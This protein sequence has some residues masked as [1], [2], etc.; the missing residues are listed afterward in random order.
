MKVITLF[1]G[2]GMTD[3]GVDRVLFTRGLP[4]ADIIRYGEFSP[5]PAKAFSIMHDIDSKHNLGDLT[6]IDARKL[7]QELKRE[8]NDDIDF[9]V[10]SFPCQSFSNAGKGLGFDDKDKGNLFN[11][12]ADIIQTLKPA[13]VVF[14]N[15]KGLLAPKY[16]A[17]AKI[18]QT[19]SGYICS[20]KVLNAI[21]YNVPQNRAR[22]FIVCIRADVAKKH[23]PFEFPATVPLT[24]TVADYIDGDVCNADRKCPQDMKKFFDEE[25]HR[26]YSSSLG[27]KKI[28]DTIKQG[29]HTSGWTRRSIFSIHGVS[30]TLITANEALYQEL[31]G[32]LTALERW[33]LMSLDD[34]DYHDLIDAGISKRQIDHIAGNGIV[35]VVFEHLFES[36]IDQGFLARF[37]P[38]KIPA[39]TPATTTIDPTIMT[40]SRP[41][42]MPSSSVLVLSATP[43]DSL[44]VKH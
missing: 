43:A 33:R 3:V 30:P 42:D 36:L 31:G 1:S 7:K 2:C 26:E 32:R 17:I 21:D 24:K 23:A 18:K 28:C 8:G 5:I 25:Y 27:I 16:G 12:S 41:V 20:H 40:M 35:T 38:K 13:V 34:S 9:I 44:A 6:K 10:S 11:V 4:R 37:T 19:M 15:V 39:D 14:E 29:Y 22:V